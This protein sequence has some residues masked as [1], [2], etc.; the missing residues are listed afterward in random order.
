M[1]DRHVADYGAGVTLDQLLHDSYR[2][3][4]E[5]APLVFLTALLVPLLG[6]LAAWVGK[7]GKTDADGRFVASAVVGLALLLVVAEVCAVVVARSVLGL[8]VLEA[9]AL[10]LVT[11]AVCLGV[12]TMGIRRV[13]PLNE[14]GSVRTAADLSLLGALLVAIGWVLSRFRFG[15]VF[16]GSMVHLA[17]IAAAVAFV[18]VRLVRRIRGPGARA[19]VA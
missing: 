9:N 7:K 14:L 2:W 13:F 11:P 8:D 18:V 6:T 5:N 1:D 4:D 16:L 10:L 17:L 15:A 3:A 12:A 19:G